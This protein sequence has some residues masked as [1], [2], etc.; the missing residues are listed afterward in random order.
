M[1]YSPATLK[2]GS[3]SQ[4]PK[5]KKKKKVLS[6]QTDIPLQ[7]WKKIYPL[8]QEITFKNRFE[9]YLEKGQSHQNQISHTSFIQ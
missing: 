6:N 1:K 9:D 4:K 8:A 3:R 2:M 7:V 5:K